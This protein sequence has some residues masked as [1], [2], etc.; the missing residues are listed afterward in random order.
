MISCSVVLTLQ[1]TEMDFEE[2]FFF[3]FNTFVFLAL[4]LSYTTSQMMWLTD[5]HRLII[6]TPALKELHLQFH[7]PFS[8]DPFLRDIRD[9]RL[10]G[11]LSRSVLPLEILVFDQL[12]SSIPSSSSIIGHLLWL[13][14][15]WLTH[16]QTQLCVKFILDKARYSPLSE[17]LVERLNREFDHSGSFPFHASAQYWPGGLRNWKPLTAKDLHDHWDDVLAFRFNRLVVASLI[18]YSFFTNRR[19]IPIVTIVTINRGL[20]HFIK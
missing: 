19:Y 7:V 5:I 2:G 4:R 15:G 13:N 20:P 6:A 1:P 10:A 11:P 9:S 16:S 3:L 8:V 17:S 18:N 12:I 14:D